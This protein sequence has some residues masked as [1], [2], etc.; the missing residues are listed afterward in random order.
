MAIFSDRLILDRPKKQDFQRFYEI[1]ADPQ[2]NLYNPYG[3]MSHKIAKEVFQEMIKHWEDNNF[4]IWKISEKENIHQI[5]GFGGLSNR[6]YGKKL[7][8][9]L[10]FRFDTLYWGKGYA[11]EFGRK[12]IE[13]GF[14]ILGKK[15]IFGLVRPKNLASIS[16]LEKCKMAFYDTLPDV[17]NEEDSLVYIIH[18]KN[19][20][21]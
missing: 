8:L 7:K 11:T 19:P 18:K 9:N 10:G 2:T 6:L 5:I 15:E 16:V 13:Y 4:G 20:K 1:N 3:A 17:P 21:N 14:D 12:A